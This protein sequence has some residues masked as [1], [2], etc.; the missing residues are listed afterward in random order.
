MDI[1]LRIAVFLMELDVLHSIFCK[2]I[3]Q[4]VHLDCSCEVRDADLTN[5]VADEAEK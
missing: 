3:E 4:N 5:T 1:S 2:I